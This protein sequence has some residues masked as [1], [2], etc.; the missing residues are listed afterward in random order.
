MPSR[1]IVREFAESQYYHVYNR[2][3]EKRLIFLDDHDYIVFLGLL[4]RYL[5]LPDK[6]KKKLP[7]QAN[8]HAHDSVRNEVSLLAYC[9]MPNHFHLLLYQTTSDGVH[10]L[11][12]RVA[13][14][15]V[16]YFNA[17][18]NRVG[19]LF[20]GPYKASL[21]TKDGYLQ[22][23]SRYIHLNPSDYKNWPYSSYP[24][25]ASQKNTPSWL[26]QAMVLELFDNRDQYL[27]FVDD[28]VSLRNELS[29]LKWQLA[30][31]LEKGEE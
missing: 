30:N 20:Q 24:Y 15:Y 27:A 29:V 14:S 8:R 31:D 2:G 12:R 26:Q 6:S 19:S 10:K 23:I 3:V 4:K 25:Y 28:Y 18:Y 5:G 22:H 7:R 13:T 1:N 11:M 9:L 21:I 16:M 17:R